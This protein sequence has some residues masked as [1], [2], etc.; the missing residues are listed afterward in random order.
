MPENIESFMAVLHKNAYLVFDNAEKIDPAMFDH[1]AIAATGATFQKRKLYSEFDVMSARS[2][3]WLCFTMINNTLRR[4]DIVERALVISM[5]RIG[6]FKSLAEIREEI[7][8]EN[9]WG[10]MLKTAKEILKNIVEHKEKERSDVMRKIRMADFASFVY[11][12]CQVKGWDSDELASWWLKETAE[13]TLG[14]SIYSLAFEQA[15]GKLWVEKDTLT[16]NQILAEVRLWVQNTTELNMREKEI[17]RAW[18]AKQ[19][20]A[21]L[22]NNQNNYEQQ[23]KIFMITTKHKTSHL[24]VLAWGG[25]IEDEE[26]EELKEEPKDPGAF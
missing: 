14:G 18:K 19:F 21:W 20:W 16:A 15:I 23:G 2:N 1:I 24:K 11:L 3:A 7:T 6:K 9:V 4:K 10:S 26:R 22:R 8:P 5:G 13:E 25:E 12:V 17:L